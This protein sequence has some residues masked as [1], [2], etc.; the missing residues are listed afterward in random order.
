MKAV[1]LILGMLALGGCASLP[2]PEVRRERIARWFKTT[3]SG[4]ASGH[5][6]QDESPESKAHH[7]QT[8][9]S[10]L[11]GWMGDHR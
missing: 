3:F 2:A 11:N 6:Y 8:V 7:E 4:D 10:T 5:S 1:I 9:V